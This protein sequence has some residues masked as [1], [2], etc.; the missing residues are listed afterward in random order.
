[1]TLKNDS[2]LNQRRMQQ[3]LDI[4]TRKEQGM[5]A[6]MQQTENSM[7]QE[8]RELKQKL[9][10]AQNEYVELE[11]QLQEK[12]KDL[13]EQVSKQ[14]AINTSL[15]AKLQADQAKANSLIKEKTNE[16]L[17]LHNQNLSLRIQMNTLENQVREDIDITQDLHRRECLFLKNKINEQQM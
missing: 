17:D 12:I 1:M 6:K 13:K 9:N 15:E 3:Q 4:I 5:E 7:Q 14:S 8:I 10:L 11:E 16:A 2:V